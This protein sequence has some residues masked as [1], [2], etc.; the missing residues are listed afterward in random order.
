MHPNRAFAWEDRDAALRFAADRTFVHVFTASEEGMFVVHVP[1]LVTDDGQ[2][3]FHVSRRNR[4]A[5][6]L[7]DRPVLISVSGR[8]AYQS[9]NWYV[10]EDQVPTWHYEAAGIEGIARPISDEAL[11]ELL[12]QLSERF[13]GIHQPERPWTRGKMTPGKFEAMMKAI[14]GFEVEPVEIRGTRKFNQHKSAEDLAATIAGQ[15]DAGREDIIQAI[16]EL[17]PNNE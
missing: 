6:H 16:G 1:I 15:R 7:A 8:E 10:S 11:V 2:V 13:E 14:V 3:L 12:D 9:A 17:A 5:E 4:I